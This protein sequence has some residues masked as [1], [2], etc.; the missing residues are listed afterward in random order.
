MTDTRITADLHLT[1][2]PVPKTLEAYSPQH[3]AYGSIEL[4]LVPASALS[5][6]SDRFR[7]DLFEDAG[8]PDP[9]ENAL[10]P[11]T[12]DYILNELGG[13]LETCR[14][15]KQLGDGVAKLVEYLALVSKI[16]GR[17]RAP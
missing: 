16:N 7:T 4:S 17:G 6:L 5:E 14:T 11:K 15:R 9:R 8:I 13:L 1:N 10:E 12:L 3:E 2:L